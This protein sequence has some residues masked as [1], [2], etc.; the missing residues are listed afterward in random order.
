M[1]DSLIR[2]KFQWSYFDVYEAIFEQGF[3]DLQNEQ[4][5]NKTLQLTKMM[6][7]NGVMNIVRDGYT[8][9]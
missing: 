9:L 8:K 5:W 3:P 6:H 4:R 2:T 7:D 1:I